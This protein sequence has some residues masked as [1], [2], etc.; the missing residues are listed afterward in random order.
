MD[1]RRHRWLDLVL[2]LGVA[3]VPGLVGTPFVD[4][5][6]YA[7]QS[8]PRWAPPPEVFG[9][10]WTSLYAS[11]AVAA[12]LVDGKAPRSPTPRRLYVAQLGLNA[13]WTPL[14]FGARRP[15]LALLEPIAL[16]V[17]AA[18]TARRFYRI[19][20]PAG[21]LFLPY[22]AWLTFAAAL[23][24]AIWRRG[25]AGRTPTKLAVAG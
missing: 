5:D 19:R 12:W 8:K 1:P 7:R 16:W 2:Q 25:R 24:A 23:N 4:R 15:G 21:L 22:L 3:F 6:W 13:L 14:F 18:L 11:Q 10:V 17:S 20:R 9:P